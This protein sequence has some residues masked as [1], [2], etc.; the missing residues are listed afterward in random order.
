[1]ADAEMTSDLETTADSVTEG[2]DQP[3][4]ALA[5]VLSWG[6]GTAPLLPSVD[7]DHVRRRTYP[8]VTGCTCANVLP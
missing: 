1:M 6:H 2:G 5:P 8:I 3:G 7:N 4:E